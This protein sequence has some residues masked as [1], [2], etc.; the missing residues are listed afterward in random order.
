MIEVG[1]RVPAVL[2]PSW[3][4]TLYVFFKQS[5]DTSRL[6]LPVYA[7]LTDYQPGVAVVGVS[8]DTPAVTEEF[9]HELG[10]SFDVVYDHPEL[11][12]STA[13]DL[14]GVPALV[15]AEAGE[16][17]FTAVGWRREAVERLSLRLAEL[18]GQGPIDLR[19]HALPAFKPG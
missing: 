18:A 7:R 6:A 16:V 4:P 10:L 5:C 13:A 12:R 19:A 2:T 1:E 8:Q 11:S 17:T 14:Q 3:D 15:L 9:L